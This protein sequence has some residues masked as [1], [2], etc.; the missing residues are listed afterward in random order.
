MAGLLAMALLTWRNWRPGAGA[1]F[2]FLLVSLLLTFQHPMLKS[3]FMH[4]W[5]AAEGGLAG[6]G[7]TAAVPLLAWKR[8][9]FARILFGASLVV[10]GAHLPFALQTGHAPEGGIDAMKLTTLP[11]VEAYLP[12]LREADNP[13]LL[14][15]MPIRDLQAWSYQEAFGRQRFSVDIRKLGPDTSTHRSVLEN[16]F[17]TAPHDAVVLVDIEADSPFFTR[18]IENRDMTVLRTMMAEQT[19]F[20][21]EMDQQLN[22]MKVRITVWRRVRSQEL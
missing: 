15:N 1:I 22:N 9:W 17:K 20:R 8:S 12:L 11:V 18:T 6:V 5:I 13:A 2:W 21:Q 3:R 7:L 14:S 19:N 10:I 16:W 4:S